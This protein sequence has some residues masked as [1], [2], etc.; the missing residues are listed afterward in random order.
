L[1]LSILIPTLYER[2][3]KL[4]SLK[5]SLFG[6][7]LS[8]NVKDQVEVK[9]MVDNR[10][11][12]TG[13]KRNHLLDA[14][15]GEYITFIDDDDEVSPDYIRLIMAALETGPDVVGIRLIHYQNGKLHGNTCHSIKYKEWKNIPGP[16]GIWTFERCPNHLNPVKREYAIKTWFPDKTSG[17]DIEYSYNLRKYLKTEVM[18]EKP[19]YYYMERV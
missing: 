7:I 14:C 6:Q 1:K 16:D 9:Y 10:I 5:A 3:D 15:E 2:V 19:I 4:I 12:S 18:I 13:K 11:L 17:E 8:N